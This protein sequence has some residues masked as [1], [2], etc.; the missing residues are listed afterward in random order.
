MRVL[1]VSKTGATPYRKKRKSPF[2]RAVSRVISQKATV[3]K[4]NYG[5]APFSLLPNTL[6]VVGPNLFG[7]VQPAVGA[8]ALATLGGDTGASINYLVGDSFTGNVIYPRNIL[9]RGVLR[10]FHYV[11]NQVV[12]IMLIRYPQTGPTP[13]LSTLFMNVANCK[14]I[15]QF[16][17]RNFTLIAKKDF[18]LRPAVHTGGFQTTEYYPGT[19]S[20]TSTNASVGTFHD[21]VGASTVAGAL[22]TTFED[23]E[24]GTPAGLFYNA[25]TVSGSFAPHSLPF[26]WNIPLSKKIRKVVYNEGPINYQNVVSGAAAVYPSQTIKDYNYEFVAYTW[27]NDLIGTAPDLATCSMDELTIQTFFK[28]KDTL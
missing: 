21:A 19:S 23:H 14:L 28:A 10:A 15:D 18:S 12:R 24:E 26:I 8:G 27:V 22:N 2:S 16:N 6:E 17:N 9:L 11:P 1:Y 7:R 4:T 20:G 3:K 5:V 25:T 13:T